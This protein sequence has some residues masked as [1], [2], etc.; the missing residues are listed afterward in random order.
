[1]SKTIDSLVQAS[2]DS[3]NFTG[4]ILARLHFDPIQRFNSSMQ[5]IYWDEAGTGD[6]AYLGL[7]NLASISVLTES[8]ELAA[9]TIQLQ[10]SGIPG[11]QITD[12]FS[13]EYIGKPVYL[14]YATVDPQTYAVQGGQNG[15]VLIFAG[16]M[17]YGAIEFGEQ[18]SI[19]INATSRLADWERPRG[20]RFN[21]SY[22]RTYIDDNDKA[23]NYVLS[24]Q[25]KPISWGGRT[26]ADPGF[27]GGAR[28]GRRRGG[29]HHP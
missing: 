25:N 6:Q 19:T 11:D 26:I 5:T 22:Q 9:Q 13:D 3:K 27:T 17:D 20:G 2:L 12:V 15:P 23:F 28:R 7:G 10:L 29:G 8:G 24:I 1:M 21:A 14:W 16:R 18:M 4:V